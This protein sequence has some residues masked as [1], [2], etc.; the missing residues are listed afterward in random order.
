MQGKAL[1]TEGPIERAAHFIKEAFNI[2]ALTGAGIS[3]SAGIPDFRSPESGFFNDPETMFLFTSWG[4]AQNPRGFYEMGKRL[5]PLFL[6]AKPTKAH[7]FL[8]RLEKMGRLRCIIT[9]NIDGLHQKAGSERVFEVHGNL[10]KGRCTGCKKECTLEE[11]SRKIADNEIPPLC[12]GCKSI[13]RPNIILFGEPLPEGV[14]LEAVEELKRC[15]LL[16]V[17]GSSL[18]VY[19]VADIPLTALEHNAKLILLNRLPTQYD[20]RA[21]VVLQMYIEEAIVKLQDVGGF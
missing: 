8:A 1:S 2:V 9:Q 5:L 11:I 6:N 18:V 16:L 3:T 21:D 19:P 14:F 13:I 17:I 15:D 4:F 20:D 12:D 7:L 10:R